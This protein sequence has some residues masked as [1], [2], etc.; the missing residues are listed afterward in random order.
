MKIDIKIC[1]C[2]AYMFIKLY[3][4]KTEMGPKHCHVQ[5]HFQGKEAEAWKSLPSSHLSVNDRQFLSID[6]FV[7][8]ISQS[9]IQYFSMS[10]Q[11]LLTTAVKQNE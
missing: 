6:V 5:H 10:P 4:L 1:N 11:H 2:D 7:V 9:E 8:L 3:Y